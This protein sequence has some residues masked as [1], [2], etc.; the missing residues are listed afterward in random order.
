MMISFSSQ[1]S[2]IPQAVDGKVPPAVV[3]KLDVEGREVKLNIC[4][5]NLL[6]YIIWRDMFEFNKMAFS[7]VDIM[8][9]L[10]MSG[11]F[12]HIDSLMVDWTDSLNDGMQPRSQVNFSNFMS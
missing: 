4:S 9:D 8:P 1:P 5:R 12:G 11:A 3:M 2:R 10:V 6:E 7:K